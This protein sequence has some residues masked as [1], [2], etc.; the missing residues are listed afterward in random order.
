MGIKLGSYSLKIK[1]FTAQELRLENVPGNLDFNIYQKVFHLWYIPVFPVEKHWKILDRTTKKEIEETTASMRSALDMKMLKKRSPVWSYSGLLILALPVLVLI[2]YVIFGA[3]DVSADGINKALA[4]NSR[5][6]SKET[7]AQTPEI[8]DLYTFKILSVDR[9]TDANGHSAGYKSSQFSA[10]FDV[11]F[12]VNYISKDSVGFD[13]NTV[14]GR[15]NYT[16]GLKNEFKLSKEE[17][18]LA[19]KNYQDLK[20]LEY[21]NEEGAQSKKIVGIFQI[22][23]KL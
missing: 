4:K 2:G 11:D 10:P 14:D 16:Y 5:I 8:G 7:L 17:L 22:D 19:T 20:I 9:V 18:L 13:H 21:P 3:I 15:T 12:L 1:T 6:S 23:R